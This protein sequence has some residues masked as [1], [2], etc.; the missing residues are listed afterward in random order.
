MKRIAVLSGGGAK[1]LIQVSCMAA[2]QSAGKKDFNK[3]YDLIIGSSVGAI[4]GT[5]LALNAM[6]PQELLINYPGMLNKIFA[7]K[8]LHFVPVY[9]RKNFQSCW[10]NILPVLTKLKECKT[11]MVISSVDVCEDTTHFFK[12]WEK[13]DGEMLAMSAV[14]KSFAAPFFFGQ[15]AD[16]TNQKVWFDGGCGSYNIPID[17]AYIEAQLLGWV[18]TEEVCID[19]YGTGFSDEPTPF[20]KASKQNFLEQLW[21]FMVPP[22]GGMARV[23]SR[24]D[25][26][27]KMTKIASTLKNIHFEYYDVQIPKKLD[28]MDDIKHKIEYAEFGKKMAEKPLISV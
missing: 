3:G 7:K 25:Q 5:I 17:F 23:Q 8:F 14:E 6:T 10:I 12:S 16:Y 9:D 28:K 13:E 27:R 19:A 26:V 1:G 22:D 15:I 4:N 24:L 21:N 2:L 18:G 20:E 11:K